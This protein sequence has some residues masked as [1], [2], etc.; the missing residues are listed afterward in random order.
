MK[1][2]LQFT[3]T[4]VNFAHMNPSL[5][6]LSESYRWHQS[7]FQKIAVIGIRLAD[8]EFTRYLASPGT[9]AWFIVIRTGFLVAF[10]PCECLRRLLSISSIAAQET[11]ATPQICLTAKIAPSWERLPTQS[12]GTERGL[13]QQPR[14]IWTSTL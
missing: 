10:R 8:P 9:F 3:L 11:T 5:T 7:T 6:R 1:M 14:M 2:Q 4:Q 13:L 12:S